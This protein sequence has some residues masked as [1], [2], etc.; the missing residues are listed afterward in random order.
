MDL[1]SVVV[2][3][4]FDG[5]MIAKFRPS[6]LTAVEAVGTALSG[7]NRSALT[8]HSLPWSSFTNK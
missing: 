2:P 6:S 8:Y 4:G 3:S 7:A 1:I 5:L